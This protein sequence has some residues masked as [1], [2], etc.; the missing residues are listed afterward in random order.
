MRTTLFNT[1]NIIQDVWGQ[2]AT[3]GFVGFFLNNCLPTMFNKEL[4]KV[5]VIAISLSV[6]FTCGGYKLYR[7]M[8]KPEKPQPG[9]YRSMDTSI[10]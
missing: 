8:I 4:S 2:A 3:G 10:V 1:I 9:D 6:F 5:T 7:E